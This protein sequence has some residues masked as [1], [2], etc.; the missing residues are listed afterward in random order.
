MPEFK[1]GEEVEFVG[2]VDPHVY[3]YVGPHGDTGEHIMYDPSDNRAYKTYMPENYRRRLP[4]KGELWARE[5]DRLAG[6]PQRVLIAHADDNFVVFTS[7]W[8][9]RGAGAPPTA[10]GNL[11]AA[12]ET[13]DFTKVRRRV[14]PA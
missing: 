10:V 9:R 6:G 2:Q 4:R 8:E 13:A 5:S 14:D 11:F 7:N 12:A 1:F 3:V